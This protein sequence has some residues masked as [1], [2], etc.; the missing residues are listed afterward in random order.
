MRDHQS[1]KDLLER[2]QTE[3]ALREAYRKLEQRV[4]ELTALNHITQILV[5]T[6]DLRTMLD[7]VSREL[8][9]IFRASSIG[10]ALINQEK[11]GFVISA[12]YG[13][14]D[15]I[16]ST[17]GSFIPIT[18]SS[19]SIQLLEHR[20]PLIIRQAQ[21]SPLTEAVHGLAR[22][23]GIQQMMLT[24]LISHGEVIGSIGI[25][26]DDE[27][28]QFT[29]T[30]ATLAE[31]IA[32]QLAGAIESIRLFEKEQRQRRI[33]ESL[34]EV[35]MV[36]N[37]RID[38]ET[39]LPQI[40]HQ[41]QHIIHYDA[42]AIFLQDG[43]QL[44]LSDGL[45]VKQSLIGR[46]LSLV[47]DNPEAHVFQERKPRIID[48]VL[49]EPSWGAWGEDSRIRSWI[50][51]PLFVGEN[52]IGIVTIDSYK[53]G[54]YRDEDAN[55]LQVFANQAA[56][57]IHNSQLYQ[58]ILREKQFVETLMLSSPVATILVDLDTCVT[59]WN[60]AAERLFGYTEREA[61]GRQLDALI[62][63]GAQYDEARAYTQDITQGA[64][65]RAITKRH[66]KNGE[67]V[68]VEIFALP[69]RIKKKIAA[70]LVLYHDITELQQARQEAEAASRAKSTFL[71]NMSHELRTPLTAILGFSELLGHSPNIP[72][73][74]QEYVATIRRNGEHLL[75]LLNNLLDL[76]RL[77]TGDVSLKQHHFNLYRLLDEL[78]YLLSSR[79]N[80][81]Q[82]E[83]L[84]TLAPNVPQ[85]VC[86]DEIKLHQVLL[87][88]LSD[89]LK[90][91][92]RG[93]VRLHIDL[94]THDSVPSLLPPESSLLFQIESRS[95]I[96]IEKVENLLPIS[97]QFVRLI[98]GEIR[99]SRT[100]A[101]SDKD[102][103]Q[104]QGKDIVFCFQ[105]PV[106][107]PD[108]EDES[109]LSG[110]EEHSLAQV[111]RP[112]GELSLQD[113]GSLPAELLDELEYAALI[114]DMD[115]FSLL[116]HKIRS[117]HSHIAE[118]LT[119]LSDRFEFVHILKLIQQTKEA[120]LHVR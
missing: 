7:K 115:Q 87:N 20:R 43:D 61:K 63:K 44:V 18:E 106:G 35:S 9:N 53:P 56:I 112:T 119:T 19:A 23:R 97:R 105:I 36:L 69:I 96:T 102:S 114:A 28:R 99:I 111:P 55:V 78:K 67:F 80:N 101:R 85:Y 57:A 45:F 47:Q 5:S 70:Y 42:A 83:L 77:E 12:D 34:Q 59:S 91:T 29:S 66:R 54:A 24:P 86:T 14:R 30:E 26:S 15:D 3:E 82:V 8:L 16:P 65:I 113:L 39:I 108:A 48:D 103:E 64:P 60:P 107:L 2:Q 98:G 109:R 68:D 6:F 88:L 94:E 4:N 90:L 76:A 25:D 27:E 10:I 21:T 17:V 79:A 89:V 40:L 75:V 50:G 118:M 71:A 58:D 32:S 100:P 92:N 72:A 13:I 46:T 31:T 74:E 104:E 73:N 81:E 120:G 51:A 95:D 22:I 33:A 93:R 11:T 62:A 1:L 49:Y 52:A 116:L 41:L 110:A 38:Q 37:S 84:I 117:S